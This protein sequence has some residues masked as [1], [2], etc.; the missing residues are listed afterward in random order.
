MNRRLAL[1]GSFSTTLLSTTGLTL[2]TGL[3]Q[4][5]STEKSADDVR[6]A[7][8]KLWEDHITYTR[9]YIISALAELP[10]AGAIAKRLVKNQD[11]I[12]EAIK[13]Y[14]G[15]EA[16][17]KLAALLK[18][19]IAIATEVVKAA[20]EGG[21][22]KTRRRSEE[23]D[24]ECRRHLDLSEQGK[25]ELGGEGTTTNAAQASRTDN[26]RSGR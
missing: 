9:N 5:A 12:G 25:S 1:I 21:E 14:Y 11:D 10:D 2:Q 4:A 7:M 8:R 26:R 22:G 13:P 23:V 16:G 20:K 24:R 3:A 19:H 17:Q 6:A 15:E 18:D